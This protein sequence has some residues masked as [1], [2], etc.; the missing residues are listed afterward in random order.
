MSIKEIEH[1]E[2]CNIF[3]TPDNDGYSGSYYYT[4]SCGAV[5]RAKAEE[6]QREG[7]K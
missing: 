1:E 3:Y 6:L 4:C 7:E 5:E 2:T